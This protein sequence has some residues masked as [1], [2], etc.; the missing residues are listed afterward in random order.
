MEKRPQ[1]VT[2]KAMIFDLILTV[3]FMFFMVGVCKSHVPGTEEPYVTAFAVFCSLPLTGV[4]WLS[5]QCFRV[6]LIDQLHQK[7]G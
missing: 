5:V 3:L 6:T 2:P 4:F 7:K 1:L